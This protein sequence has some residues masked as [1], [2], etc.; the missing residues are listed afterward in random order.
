MFVDN[1]QSTSFFRM[2]Q[3]VRQIVSLLLLL[4]LCV[5]AS[6]TI[7][8]IDG[9]VRLAKITVEGKRNG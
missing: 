8:Y 9:K 2:K 5:L 6:N 4:I 3:V 7:L 1:P